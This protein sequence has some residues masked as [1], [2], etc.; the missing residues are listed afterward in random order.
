MRRAARC[1]LTGG[2][3]GRELLDV[4]GNEEET[5]AG[6]PL[7]RRRPLLAVALVPGSAGSE[8]SDSEMPWK[9]SSD[10]EPVGLPIEA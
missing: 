2:E 10:G 8:A 3:R 6:W 5:H 4:G 9:P 1:C 7:R